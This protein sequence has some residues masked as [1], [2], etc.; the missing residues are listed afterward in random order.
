MNQKLWAIQDTNGPPRTAP[1][2][3]AQSLSRRAKA[4]EFVLPLPHPGTRKPRVQGTPAPGLETG[5]AVYPGL[6]PWAKAL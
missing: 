2:G 5:F 3:A 6:T 1:G 4:I